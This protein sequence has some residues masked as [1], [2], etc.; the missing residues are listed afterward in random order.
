MPDW[1][2]VGRTG[3]CCS[4]NT[5]RLVPE[6][7]VRVGIRGDE[8]WPLGRSQPSFVCR[9]RPHSVVARTSQYKLEGCSVRLKSLEERTQLKRKSCV[10]HK[11][12]RAARHMVLA[13]RGQREPSSPC[14]L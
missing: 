14:A 4:G 5:I 2:S 3:G 1:L 10:R 7:S 8:A 6:R 9:C 12:F 13:T 11:I